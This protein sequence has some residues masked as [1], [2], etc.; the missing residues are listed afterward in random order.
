MSGCPSGGMLLCDRKGNRGI[1]M[2]SY[3]VTQRGKEKEE[4]K[5]KKRRDAENQLGSN[6]I[7]N[8]S[9]ITLTL[10]RYPPF[11]LHCKKMPTQS[12]TCRAVTVH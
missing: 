12:V 10:F 6:G 9:S 2:E 5:T 3:L 7:P 1:P 11:T 8:I 4:Y